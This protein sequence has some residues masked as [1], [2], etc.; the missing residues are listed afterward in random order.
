MP[1]RNEREMLRFVETI[2]KFL[3]AGKSAVVRFVHRNVVRETPKRTGFASGWQAGIG[4]PPPIE[5]GKPSKAR[6]PIPG[7]AEIDAITEQSDLGDDIVMV[8]P[9]DYIKF[10]ESPFF[11]SPQQQEPWI[12]P[13]IEEARKQLDAWEWDGS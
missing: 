3:K 13:A 12:D 8:S 1:S 7:D 6:Y 4:G 9:A 10:L 2:F 11:K 5:P